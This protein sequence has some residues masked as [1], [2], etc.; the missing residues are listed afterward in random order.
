MAFIDKM[1]RHRRPILIALFLFSLLLRLSLT[2]NNFTTH[3]TEGWA[4]SL[5]YLHYGQSFAEGDFY[6]EF[7]PYP[8][9]VTGPIIPL[10]VTAS[11]VI[12]GDPIVPV[13]IF[14]CLLSALLVFVL[15]YIGKKIVNPLTGYLLA[16]WS[17]FNISLINYNNRIL[18]EPLLFL[19]VPLII[20][21]LVNIY[22]KRSLLLNIIASSL[23]FSVLIHTDE[24]FV[25]YAPIFIIFVFLTTPV[26]KK[27]NLS[28]I[29][30]AVLLVTMVPWT[31]RNY[32]EFA[33][34]V[35]ISPRTTAITSKI[36][37]TDF[38]GAHFASEEGIEQEMKQHE[39]RNIYLANRFGIEP[40][41]FG[42]I[43]KY[44]KTF[45]H[46]WQPAFFRLTYTHHGYIPVKWSLLHNLNSLLFYGIFLPFYLLGMIMA[47]IK[48]N[49]LI[50]F[51]ASIP[52]IHS[53]IHTIMIW[54]IERYRWPMVF[55]IVLIAF[56]Y[57]FTAILKNQEVA[58]NIAQSEEQRA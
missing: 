31:M 21:C 29:W 27:I 23:L 56:W 15:F 39:E 11:L 10:I 22:Y 25:A 51:L 53:I 33:E 5:Y 32:R 8:Y 41:R 28:I 18:K 34:I 45:I 55:L 30:L 42:T 50:L 49:W 57:L 54:P 47:V 9:M 20:L 6:P 48:R 26:K 3:G 12:T 4:D 13:L 35:I 19:L 52:L 58:V 14:N 1:D 24:R 38:A 43:E 36:W 7:G 44:F 46:Y 37:G 17:V 16:I 40:R 2:Y